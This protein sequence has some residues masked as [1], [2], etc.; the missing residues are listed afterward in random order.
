MSV[1]G[2]RRSIGIDTLSHAAPI[3]VAT[4]VGPLLTCSITAP[5]DPGTKE[6]PAETSGQI[7]NLFLHVGEV[8]KVAGGSWEHVA[9]MTFYAPDTSLLFEPLNK[10]W[11]QHFPEPTSRPS[12]H[13]MQVDESWGDIQVCCDFLAFIED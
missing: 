12:R 4:R 1:P 9:K 7:S 10:I 6:C 3:P 13:V 8:L 5:Y 11:V 2:G